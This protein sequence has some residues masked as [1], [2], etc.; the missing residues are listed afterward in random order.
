MR[1]FRSLDFANWSMYVETGESRRL[2]WSFSLTFCEIPWRFS[3]ILPNVKIFLTVDKIPWQFPDLEK[4]YFSLTFPWRLWTLSD[5]GLSPGRRQ[6]I[7][8]TNA[9]ILLI[10]TLGTNFSEILIEIPIFSFRKIH[11]EPMMVILLT[12]ICVTRPEWVNGLAKQKLHLNM[13]SAKW[14]Q[15]WINNFMCQFPSELV[16]EQN[17]AAETTATR[18]SAYFFFE[19]YFV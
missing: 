2:K 7:I 17:P 18:I 9:G 8:W 13:A 15:F 16:M 1:K 12:H 10:G 3:S 6:A 4:F 19:N 11:S 5:N 14:L